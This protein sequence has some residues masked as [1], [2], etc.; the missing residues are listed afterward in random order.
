MIGAKQYE[1]GH[2][3]FGEKEENPI[4]TNMNLPKF[5][6][7][8]QT[9]QKFPKLL[10]PHH[11][12]LHSKPSLL[13]RFKPT[14]VE[15]NQ[16]K[17]DP[18]RY[19]KPKEIVIKKAPPK[20]E[21]IIDMI[22]KRDSKPKEISFRKKSNRSIEE[23]PFFNLFD[24]FIEHEPMEKEEHEEEENKEEFSDDMMN[25][26]T[27]KVFQNI[28]KYLDNDFKRI[29]CAEPAFAGNKRIRLEIDL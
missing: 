13:D 7:I 16:M 5:N 22:G 21:S 18:T 20:G 23:L 10:A 3:T 17:Y 12:L 6:K 15:A 9:L 26:I 4:I 19:I 14:K 2:K 28:K 29:D 11:A 25:N 24:S 1:I 27:Y 8:E